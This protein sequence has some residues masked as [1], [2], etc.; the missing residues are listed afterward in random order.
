MGCHH[1]PH[2]KVAAKHTYLTEE[3]NFY[4]IVFDLLSWNGLNGDL[5]MTPP[6]KNIFKPKEMMLT[7]KNVIY[8]SSDINS[9]DFKILTIR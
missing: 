5:Q 8:E 2:S 1:I 6:D 4:T 3:L 9:S 7:M